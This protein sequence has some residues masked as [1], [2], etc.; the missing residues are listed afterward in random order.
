MLAGVLTAV[1]V[2]PVPPQHWGHTGVH[3]LNATAG[4]TPD[5]SHGCIN[6]KPYDF[7]KQFVCGGQV[8]EW[9]DHLCCEQGRPFAT[10]DEYCCTGSGQRGVHE[11][12]VGKCDFQCPDQCACYD[13]DEE[14]KEAEDARGLHPQKAASFLKAAAAA[15]TLEQ[16]PNPTDSLI[17]T[18]TPPEGGYQCTD[19][20]TD[21]GCM[22]G[23]NYSYSLYAP[24]G[25]YLM[26]Y[27]KWGCCPLAAPLGLTPYALGSVYCCKNESAPVGQDYA[28]S[29]TACKCH[30][31]GC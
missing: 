27:G 9:T 26:Q 28:L 31:Y 14:G 10:K 1:G 29:H 7:T 3:T 16:D 2:T 15:A 6:G 4:C 17:D 11:Y 5:A 19:S 23:Y 12:T 20:A 25:S 8:L 22:N 30:R 18:S 21:S 24:C 13:E